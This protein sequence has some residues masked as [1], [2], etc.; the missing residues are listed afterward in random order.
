MKKVKFILKILFV[1]HSLFILSC[2]D[3]ISSVLTDYNSDFKQEPTITIPQTDLSPDDA[4]FVSSNMLANK[5]FV[6]TNGT[7]NLYAPSTSQTYKWNLLELEETGETVQKTEERQISYNLSNG[8]TDSS[9][10][11]ILYIPTS[12]LTVGTY[13]LTLTITNKEGKEFS[14]SCS[15]I[16]YQP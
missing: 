10:A 11:F 14:D 8:S 4:N 5:Y 13:K 15:I 6:P 1:F 7:L 3:S 9:R 16:V 12:L 2:S